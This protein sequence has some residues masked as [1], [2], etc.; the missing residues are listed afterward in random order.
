MTRLPLLLPLGLLTVSL[1]A[2]A[3]GTEDMDEFQRLRPQTVLRVDILSCSLLL[4][5][6][7]I[8]LVLLLLIHR[9]HLSILLIILLGILIYHRRPRKSRHLRSRNS[10][11][12][13]SAGAYTCRA[14]HV[15]A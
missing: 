10:Q 6:I 9:H 8:L 3:E 1:P 15:G 2:W 11:N 14:S 5:I 12:R 4:L 7:I 13:Q